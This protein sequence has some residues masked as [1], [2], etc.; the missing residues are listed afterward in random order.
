MPC[1][2]SVPLCSSSQNSLRNIA[3]GVFTHLLCTQLWEPALLLP[4]TSFYPPWGGALG[5]LEKVFGN[6]IFQKLSSPFL[7]GSWLWP[8]CSESFCFRGALEQPPCSSGSLTLASSG[9]HPCPLWFPSLAPPWPRIPYSH[10]IVACASSSDFLVICLYCFFFQ[11]CG[12]SEF[13]PRKCLS[14]DDTCS[15]QLILP[16]K[17]HYSFNQK[18]FIIIMK[19]CKCLLVYLI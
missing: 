1:Y 2:P 4:P 8:C 3:L 13:S 11:L 7:L 5:V 15:P 17:K 19:T 10:Y 18:I 16:L 14:T 6:F 12:L 9:S